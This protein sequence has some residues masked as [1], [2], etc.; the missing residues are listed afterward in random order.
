[1]FKILFLTILSAVSVT[2]D[3]DHQNISVWDK[4][5]K[6][7]DWDYM[8]KVPIELS[9]NA[10]TSGVYAQLLAIN[11]SILD[12]GCAEGTVVNY[13]N[14]IQR[15][16][17]VGVD[18]SAAA[19]EKARSNHPGVHFEVGSIKDYQ[20]DQQFDLMIFNDVLMFAPVES[21][22]PRFLKY[23]KPGGYM[24]ISAFHQPERDNNFD[25]IPY[26]E[27]ARSLMRLYDIIKVAGF[28]WHTRTTENKGHFEE[29]QKTSY[30]T[31]VFC[32]DL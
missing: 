4:G 21:G 16:K 8:A 3:W 7:G 11:G 6:D 5:W 32:N 28:V 12:V 26:F 23:L 2:S 18:W 30:V 14:P 15:P 13:L 17:Y 25:M 27:K 31:Q 24:I 29:R 20:P 1:M 10:I 9:R 19:I 22:I